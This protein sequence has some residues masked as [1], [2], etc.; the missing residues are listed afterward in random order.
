MPLFKGKGIGRFNSLTFVLAAY[1]LFLSGTVLLIASALQIYFNFQVEQRLIASQQQLVAESAADTVRNFIQEKF[2]GLVIT[3]NVADFMN[4]SKGEQELILNRL[5]GSEP[6]FRR[7]TVLNLW[8]QELAKASRLSEIVAGPLADR[9]DPELFFNISEGQI[10]N[11][12]VY[13]DEAT[14]EPL[15]LTAVSITNVFGD[16]E[17]VLV[18]ELNLKFMWDLVG[19]IKIGER[20]LVYVVDK[21]G[22]LIAFRDISR[23]LEGENLSQLTEVRKFIDN[24]DFSVIKTVIT[25][26]IENTRVASTF[27]PLGMPDWAVIVESP[28]TEA[29]GSI[30]WMLI[31]SSVIIALNLILALLVSRYL[32]RRITRPIIDLR[33]AARELSKG[34]LNTRIDIE[35][36]DEIGELA[37]GFNDMAVKVQTR[38]RQLS[39]GL[40]RL[41]SLV[42]SIK[43]GVIMVDLSLNVVLANS[44]AKIIF[45]KSPKEPLLFSEVEG[46]LKDVQLSQT[47]SRYVQNGKSTI[48]KEAVFDGRHFRVFISTVR[49]IVEKFFIGAVMVIEDV[50]AEKMLDQMRT[51]IVSTTS[52]QLRTPLSLIK[53]N[54]EMVLGGN[55]GKITKEQ[56]DV[57]GEVFL[58]NER[59]IE[60]VNDLMDVSKITEGK[61]ALKL[62]PIQL[63]DLVAQTVEKMLPYAQSKG[64]SLTYVTSPKSLPEVNADVH[65]IKDALQNLIDNA[66]KYS[67]INHK[68]QVQVSVEQDESDG[69]LRV[70]IKDNGVGIPKNEQAEVFQRFFRASNSVKMDPGGGTGLGLYIAKAVIEQSGG[71][72]WFES[73]ENKGTTFYFTMPLA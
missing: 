65:R 2:H 16:L 62:E 56:K 35:S 14:Q 10:Y 72:I 59:M 18:A 20:G 39:E 68:G 5:L 25:E 36:R 53:G 54:L 46:R 50:T 52:H 41:E 11:S 1:F 21:D 60:L 3:A 66:I 49:D 22:N 69:F 30:I 12:P 28:V 40:G 51:E 17:G 23:V 15:I 45:G 48:A 55:I 6:F 71:K 31:L 61:F 19:S 4:I 47:L 38:T 44:A 27:E 32:S 24:N 26:G 33:D 70:A 37:E 9:L 42:E 63:D 73:E 43:L 58:S 13:I 34:R 57:L 8:G 29:Y 67:K 64:V 7:L